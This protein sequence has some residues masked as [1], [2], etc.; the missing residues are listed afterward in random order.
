MIFVP[1]DRSH[2]EP[3]E[4]QGMPVI[5]VTGRRWPAEALY[6]DGGTALQGLRL[7]A[8]FQAYARSIM[9]AG[10]LT[11]FVPRES[12]PDR[13][14]K[15]L[16]AVVLAGGLDLDP[17]LYGSEVTA[18]TT[19]L[20]PEQD[21]FDIALA[22]AA[23]A[24]GIPVLGTCRGHEV[25]NVALGGTLH[26]HGRDGHNERGEPAAYR[27]HE[28]SIAEGSLLRSLYGAR[29]PVNSLHHQAIASP[30]PGV[31]VTARSDDG[32]VEAIELL[33]QSAVGVQWHP[34]LHDGLDPILQW[35]VV[36]ARERAAE[37]D[38]AMAL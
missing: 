17:A 1:M 7:D 4:G 20:D 5:G 26:D 25:L 14:V 21:A 3:L 23:I 29:A 19:A 2:G 24:E 9:E 12:D 35:L 30:A 36:H 18:E 8:F 6:P 31:R 11:V 38:R 22:H 37:L 32:L 28:V 33:E 13:L 27:A 34:E 10:G 16:D 15:R